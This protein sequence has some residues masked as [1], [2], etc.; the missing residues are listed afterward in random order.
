MITH[1]EILDSLKEYTVEEY[2]GIAIANG[3]SQVTVCET[4]NNMYPVN[5]WTTLA[6]AYHDYLARYD[7]GV[8][9]ADEAEVAVLQKRPEGNPG[10]KGRKILYKGVAYNSITEAAKANGLTKKAME[11]K[12]EYGQKVYE[13]NGRQYYKKAELLKK[14]NMTAWEYDRKQKARQIVYYTEQVAVYL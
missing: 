7:L 1:K 5:C 10:F 11:W 8:Q 14:E 13:Y 3:W 9:E 6:E 12:L 2:I 4:L